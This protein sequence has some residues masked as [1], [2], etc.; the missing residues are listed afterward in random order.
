MR[1]RVTLMGVTVAAIFGICWAPDVIAHN[2]DCFTSLS[3]SQLTYAIVHMIVLFSSTV[4]PFVYA[5]VNKN[6]REK[7]KG[8]IYCSCT[9][10]ARSTRNRV[11]QKKHDFHLSDDVFVVI[12]KK[13]K[14]NTFILLMLFFIV[15]GKITALYRLE[16]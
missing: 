6:F 4:N 1:K 7:L 14:T 10:F 15:K 8:M 3:V 16:R 13:K 2:L 9:S 11:C 12:K 5:L